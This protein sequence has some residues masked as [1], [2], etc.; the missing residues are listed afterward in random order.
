MAKAA[1]GGLGKSDLS[2]KNIAVPSGDPTGALPAGPID[3]YSQMWGTS[4]NLGP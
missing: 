4:S 1:Q 3:T 2:A